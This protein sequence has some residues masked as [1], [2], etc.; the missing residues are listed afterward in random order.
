[1]TKQENMNNEV[2]KNNKIVMQITREGYKWYDDIG[3]IIFYNAT[4]D[5]Q[6]EDKK[7]F[8]GYTILEKK[9]YQEVGVCTWEELRNNNKKLVLEV[10]HNLREGN[11][12]QYTNYDIEI[13]KTKTISFKEMV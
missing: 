8:Q 5:E 4:Y 6:W 7:S 3:I 2:N 13:I 1:M 9:Y 12:F 11:N 10:K